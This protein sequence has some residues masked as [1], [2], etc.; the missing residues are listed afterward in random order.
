MFISITAILILISQYSSITQVNAAGYFPSRS[1]NIGYVHQIINNVHITDVSIKQ[2]ID[3]VELRNEPGISQMEL[4]LSGQPNISSMFEYRIL[5]A[6]TG[7]LSSDQVEQW[8]NQD[9]INVI[10]PETNVTFCVAGGES[11][12]GVTNGSSSAYYNSD[13]S[14][15]F[16]EVYNNSVN[17]VNNNTL[18]FPVTSSPLENP[19]IV[20]Q[21]IVFTSFNATVNSSQSVFYLDS[22]RYD[23]IG[24][25]FDL[26]PK[27]PSEAIYGMTIFSC[28]F[29]PIVVFY[30]KRKIYIQ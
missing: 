6:W 2:T 1:D 24:T 23:F 21:A 3:V 20:S 8:P 30:R 16:S 14:L 7:L 29:I 13:G 26:G 18:V 12:F 22:L 4:E 28:I 11:W 15:V 19:D 9:W 25:M 27:I 17:I 10:T 5:L